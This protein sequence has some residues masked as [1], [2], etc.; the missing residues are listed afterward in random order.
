[1]ESDNCVSTSPLAANAT[2]TEPRMPRNLL[3]P[4][5][6][7]LALLPRLPWPPAEASTSH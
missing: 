1:V 3:L 2:C 7:H 6:S 5:N 4:A